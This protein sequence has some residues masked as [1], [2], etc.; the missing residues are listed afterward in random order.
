MLNHQNIKWFFAIH[1]NDDD[2]DGDRNATFFSTSTR[3]LNTHDSLS[4][5]TPLAIAIEAK[6]ISLLEFL[7]DFPNINLSGSDGNR[8]T[9]LHL[10]AKHVSS[11]MLSVSTV[12]TGCFCCVVLCLVTRRVGGV[13]VRIHVFLL[14]LFSVLFSQ[15]VLCR[16]LSSVIYQPDWLS[17]MFYFRCRYLS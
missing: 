5:L 9:V 12:S 15:L 14:R 17:S 4:D 3:L 16:P 11:P 2:G 1:D 8:N 7:L 6:D 10:S 13:I